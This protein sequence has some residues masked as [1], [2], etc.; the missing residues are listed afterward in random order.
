MI[1]LLP[2]GEHRVN[3]IKADR[4]VAVER[5]KTELRLWVDFG[6]Y[7]ESYV[8]EGDEH[9]IGLA[10]SDYLEHYDHPYYVLDLTRLERSPAPWQWQW[11][12]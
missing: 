9:S 7:V 2:M 6:T 8:L 10:W 4:V 12:D 11:G 5:Y 3:A 1:V